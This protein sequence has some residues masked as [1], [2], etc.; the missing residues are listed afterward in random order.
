MKAKEEKHAAEDVKVKEE[1]NFAKD[2]KTKKDKHANKDAKAKEDEHSTFKGQPTEQAHAEF[3]KK[4]EDSERM[5]QVKADLAQKYQEVQIM[6]MHNALS[7]LR[8][9]TY[10]NMLRRISH[11]IEAL[12][13]LG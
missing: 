5:E 7:A 9:K 11:S 6:E 2:V 12:G 1:K 3:K 4:V 8:Q 13:R 10:E